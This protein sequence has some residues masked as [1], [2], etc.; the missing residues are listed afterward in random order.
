MVL[1]DVSNPL[2]LWIKLKLLGQTT[3]KDPASLFRLNL[4]NQI[5]NQAKLKG[6]KLNFI[7][8]RVILNYYATVISKDT[9][10]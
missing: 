8:F 10:R 2:F 3:I 7:S 5:Q 4:V 9:C 6:F 1:K